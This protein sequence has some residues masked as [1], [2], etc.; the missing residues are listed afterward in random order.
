MPGLKKDELMKIIKDFD[1]L[2][3]RSGTKVTKDVIDA[4][5]NL[6][7]IGRAGTGVDNIDCRSATSR[8]ILV[9]NTPGGNTISTGE[10][11]LAHILALA[12]NI[13]QSSAALKAGRWDRA[14]YTG[15]ELSGKV[16]GVIGV[17]RIG[18]EVAKWCRGFGMSTIGFDPVMSEQSARSFGVEPV[19]LDELFRTAD[20]ITIHT[21]LTKD[22]AYLINAENLAKCKKGVRIINCARGG[23]IDETALLD[24]IKSG[25]VGG[26]SLDV[27]EVEPPSEASLELRKHPHVVV[28]PHLGASTVDAQERVAKAVAE[29]MSDILDGGAFVGVV[30]AP[31]LGAVA[32]QEH[33]VPYVKLAE[34]IG[35]MQGQLLKN[36]KIASITVNLRGK[37]IS[38]TKLTDVIKAA[39]IKGA[40]S[41][42]G[43]ANLNYV[44][45]LGVAEEMG[46]RVLVNMSEKTE[47]GSGYRNSIGVELELDGVFNGVR[48]IEG[49]V[50]GRDELRVTKIDGYSVELPP[51]EHV[52]L[53]N[54][55]DQPGVLKGIM[56]RLAEENINIAH[57]SVGRQTRG[58]KA[59]GAVVLDTPASPG[60]IAALSKHANLSNVIQLNLKDTSDPNFRVRNSADSGTHLSGLRKPSVKPRNPE[61]SSGPCKKRPGYDLG[62]LR[63]DSL[64]RSHRSKL[65]KSRLK[66]AIEDTKRI[67]E[68]PEDYLCGIVAG[69]DTGAYEMAMWNM[70]GQ[71]PVDACYWESFG[72]GWNDDA[73]KH[74]KLKE[75]TRS[76]TADYGKLPDFG[77]TNPDHDILFTFN[78][79][80][81][82]VRVPNLDWVS[83]NRQGLTFN[84]ATSAAFAMEID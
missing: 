74:L 13:P 62:A 7:I 5:I 77:A 29:N 54:N 20:F 28:T 83:P 12:R 67:L 2:V 52:L 37:D 24:A 45:A 57:F 31:D 22:T 35:S 6:K 71:R 79:T 33:I 19:A 41:E 68:I 21:P 34:R 51:G 11:A 73:I 50:F 58:A 56:E 42:L 63:T 32:K 10:L 65:G 84:D 78:G 48:T 81:S 70:L 82:G 69:S 44:S 61:F 36:S 26:A 30:N 46:L 14:L 39:V 59:M 75:T 27:F 64:G 17:G 16:L 60:L 3:V 66:K 76:F 55:V 47:Q 18:R 38:D 72:K 40:L 4:G 1:G 25:Q 9:V 43:I 80:T 23:I 8:G 15:T 49:T 53:W